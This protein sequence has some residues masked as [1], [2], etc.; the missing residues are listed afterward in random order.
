MTIGAIKETGAAHKVELLDTLETIYTELVKKDGR[1]PHEYPLDGETKNKIMAIAQSHL[2]R[3]AEQLHGIILNLAYEYYTGKRQA[4]EYK[5]EIEVWAYIADKDIEVEDKQ[6]PTNIKHLR[7][8]YPFD[9]TRTTTHRKE[10]G[11]LHDVIK[12]ARNYLKSHY[13]ETCAPHALTDYVIEQIVLE[14]DTAYIVIGS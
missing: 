3:A 1:K 10:M 4:P 5:E 2:E 12:C 9:G 13:R 8:D 11:Y 6:L 7:F 14:G